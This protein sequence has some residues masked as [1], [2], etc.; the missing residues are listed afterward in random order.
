MPN[1]T[2]LSIPYPNATDLVSLGYDQI[3]DVA[4]GIDGFFGAWTSYTP[5]GTNISGGSYAAA[6]KKIGK[7]GFVRINITAGTAT[8]AGSVAVTLPS[9]W[10]PAANGGATAYAPSAGTWTAAIGIG[11][12]VTIFNG[13][14][15]ANFALGATVVC[16]MQF[17]IE[18]N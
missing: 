7:I 6:Y 13:T 11:G 12:T 1:T 2:N 3:A 5:T 10:T 16:R 17:V 9:G 4:T 8:A 18:L 14:G 15:T